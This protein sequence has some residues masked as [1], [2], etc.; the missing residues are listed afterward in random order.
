MNNSAWKLKSSNTDNNQQN[1]EY[2][3]ERQRISKKHDADNE[4]AGTTDTGP[5]R[6]SRPDGYVLLRKPEKV[7][8]QGHE[9]QGDCDAEP[10]RLR[11]LRNFYTDRPAYL[12]KPGQKQIDPT[13]VQISIANWKIIPIQ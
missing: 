4:R 12:E 13:H 2:A 1:P 6:V 8:A 9:A 3:H 11:G 10:A 5:D 7:P